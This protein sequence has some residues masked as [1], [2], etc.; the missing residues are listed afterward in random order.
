[1][2]E[3][4]VSNMLEKL[5]SRYLDAEKAYQEECRSRAANAYAEMLDHLREA[6]AIES[7][8][9]PR[10]YRANFSDENVAKIFRVV[11]LAEGY[12]VSEVL[13]L[14]GISTC[15]VSGWADAAD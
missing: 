5:R 12:K 9:P 3:T 11:L 6:M 7:N 2:K 10:A 14:A 15:E 1:M 4:T 8:C 13:N